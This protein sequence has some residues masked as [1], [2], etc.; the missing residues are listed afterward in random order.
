MQNKML[1]QDYSIIHGYLS[2]K[3]TTFWLPSKRLGLL[4]GI[5][6]GASKTSEE[7]QFDTIQVICYD[8]MSMS[9]RV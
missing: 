6:E 2:E 7:G 3:K 1:R 4:F 5:N 9:P 8:C